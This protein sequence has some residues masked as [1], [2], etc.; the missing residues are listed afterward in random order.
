MD[1]IE[2]D[3]TKKDVEK[4]I[5]DHVEIYVNSEKLKSMPDLSREILREISK[6]YD[7]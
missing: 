6:K 4:I 2:I 1:K 3:T 7:L 5:K